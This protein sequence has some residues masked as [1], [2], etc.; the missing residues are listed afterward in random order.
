VPQDDRLTRVGVILIDN[1][2][3]GLALRP[4]SFGD[5]ALSLDALTIKDLVSRPQPAALARVEHVTVINTKPE[6]VRAQIRHNLQRGLPELDRMPVRPLWGR[7][8]TFCGAGPSLMQHLGSLK[9][10]V[11]AANA[12][13]PALHAA[14]VRV[15]YPMVWDATPEMERY[16]CDIPGAEWMIASRVNPALI[17]RLLEL[18]QK[19]TL[20]HAG[21]A[22]DERQLLDLISG[23]FGVCGGNYS[24]T[25]APFLL[26]AMGFRDIHILGADSSFGIASAANATHVGGSLRDEKEIAVL[27]EGHAYRT[28]LWMKHQAEQWVTFLLPELVPYG[29]RFA[30]HGDGLLPAAHASWERQILPTLPW[31]KRLAWRYSPWW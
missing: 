30:V 19:V 13:I 27:F 21:L 28:T 10:K 5:I 24:A 3:R 16:A 7:T 22:A 2:G 11:M 26:A 20:W 25:R 1:G 6:V 23:R 12:A 9:G 17:D 14:R 29:L 4:L 8:A 15:D 31:H 18:G